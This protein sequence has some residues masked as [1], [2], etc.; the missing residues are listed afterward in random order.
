[1]LR[2]AFENINVIELGGYIVGSYCGSLLADLGANVIKFEP[3]TGDGLRP[4]LGAFQGWNRGVK[5]V[6]V[7]LRTD[8]GKTILNKLAEKADVLVQNLRQGIAEQWEADYASLS[9]INPGI[10]YWASPGYGQSGPYIEKPAFDPLLQA[11]S[12]IMDAQ[13]G[14]GSPPVYLRSSV[15]DYTG[16]MLGA[17]GV[18]LALFNRVKTG[19]GQ[20][21]HSALL[22]ASIAAQSG[23]LLNYNGKKEE[24]RM[25]YWGKEATYRLYRTEDD[26]IFIGFEDDTS[27]LALCKAL[28][29][30]E[31]T[32]ASEFDTP[33]KRRANAAHLAQILESIF[34]RN[35]S[36]HWLDLLERAEIPCS[37]VNYSR[38]LFT[39]PQILENDLMFEHQTQSLGPLKQQGMLIKLSETPGNLQRGAPGLGQHTDEILAELGYSEGSIQQ[40]RENRI[41]L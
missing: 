40:M 35:T 6:A 41:I 31:L 12:G 38:D 8:E 34:S 18:A 14:T 13:G 30:E 33:A 19:K 23:E 17:F 9:R 36:Q 11:R 22:N 7:N 26:W 20:Y 25:E 3:L 37:P 10:V 39:H 15:C 4:Q 21:L 32:F 1:M 2:H 24:P 28:D 29:H 27:W 5:G 16:A